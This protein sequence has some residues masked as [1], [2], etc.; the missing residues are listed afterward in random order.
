GKHGAY[1]AVDI[2]Y[3]QFNVYFLTVSQS[4]TSQFDQLVIQRLVEAVILLDG[5]VGACVREHSFGRSQNVAQVQ[6]SGLPV[7]DSA[8]AFQQVHTTHH[9]GQLANTQTCHDFTQLFSH[10]EQVVHDVFRLAFEL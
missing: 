1:N 6:A 4:R 2:H 5:L 3:W 8:T 10:H 7:V 9:V